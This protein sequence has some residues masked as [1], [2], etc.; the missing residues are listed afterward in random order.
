MTVR[1]QLVA[2]VLMI[3]VPAAAGTLVTAPFPGST[4]SAGVAYCTVSNVGTSDAS[5][6]VSIVTDTGIAAATAFNYPLAPGKSATPVS[7]GLVP[8][9]PSHCVFDGKGKFRGSFSYVNGG[10]VVVIPAGK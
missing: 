5:V 3:A 2:S 10:T 7:L 9:K 6:S 8:L 1:V 4:Q